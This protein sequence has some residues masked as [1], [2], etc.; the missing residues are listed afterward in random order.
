MSIRKKGLLIF[1][2]FIVFILI[3]GSCYGLF[4]QK[5]TPDRYNKIIFYYLARKATKDANNFDEKVIALRDLVHKNIHPVGQLTDYESMFEFMIFGNGWCDQQSRVFMWLARAIGITSRLLFLRLESGV[6]PHSVAEVLTPDNRWVIVDPLFS[7]DLITKDGKLAGQDDIKKDIK[8]LTNSKQVR[9]ALQYGDRWSDP[10][11]L[12]I[13]YNPPRYVITKKGSPFDFLRAIP[14]S[15]LKPIINI[16]Q[17]RYFEQQDIKNKYSK[18]GELVFVKA[19]TFHLLG[20]YRESDRLYDKLIDESKD[21]QLK[22][23]TQFYKA[24][25]LKDEGRYQEAVDYINSIENGPYKSI[26]M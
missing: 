1:L 11:F 14:L 23:K 24:L 21:A 16:I 3:V 2:S 17:Q 13:Y 4:I 26:L 6:S 12:A 7:L 5:I 18:E 10:K 22:Q 9:S 25:L 20:Y 15:L 19:R 8:I